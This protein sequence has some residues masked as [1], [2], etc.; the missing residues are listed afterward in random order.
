MRLW[1]GAMAVR[2]HGKH[3][4]RDGVTAAFIVS[5]ITTM[6]KRICCEN[7]FLWFSPEAVGV[8]VVESQWL[9]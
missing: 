6:K 9:Q 4:E 1:L 5:N 8:A 7:T 2:R 3:G